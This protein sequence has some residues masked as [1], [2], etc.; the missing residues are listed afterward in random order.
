MLWCLYYVHI[1]GGPFT[2]C[3]FDPNGV[4]VSGL[5]GAL[6]LIPHSID[7]D[8]RKVGVPGEVFAD[9]VHDKKSIHCHVEKVDSQGFHYRVHFTPKD[10]GKHRVSNYT[11]MF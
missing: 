9:I 4:K 7:L 1:Q 6:P 10:A 11:I 5:E 8:C 3:V 2:C